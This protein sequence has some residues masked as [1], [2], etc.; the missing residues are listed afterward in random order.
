MDT[1]TPGKTT[2]DWL[3]F[4]RSDYI[5]TQVILG[6][7]VAGSVLFGLA[8]PILD[9]V[10]NTPLP[11]TYKTSA[12]S[13][14]VELPRGATVDGNATV[15]LL[16]KDATS[17]ERLTQAL[18]AI[19]IA[20]LTIA[21]AWLLFQLIRSTQAGEPFTRRN[22]WRINGIALMVGLG[23]LLVQLAGGVADNAIQTSGRLPHPDTLTLE[24]T[25]T[26]LPLVAMIAIA[27]VGEAFRRGIVLREDV[28]G[29]V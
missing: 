8:V 2:R 24:M 4:T 29:L 19:L 22:V 16:L 17:G 6:I 20:G 12:T 27:L 1:N 21:V 9:A 11:V 25:F 15:D 26:P 14:E 3:I 10:N 28:E 5:A 13:S 18:P 7:A 23:G